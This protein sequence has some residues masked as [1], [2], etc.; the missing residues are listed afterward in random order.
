MG[1]EV[2]RGLEAEKWQFKE[3]IEDKITKYT[4]YIAYAVSF[5]STRQSLKI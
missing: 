4:V 1:K 5:G 2:V 3:A